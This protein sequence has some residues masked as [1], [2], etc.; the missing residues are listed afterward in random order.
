M[1][2]SYRN[3]GLSRCKDLP[4]NYRALQ[5]YFSNV[6]DLQSHYIRIQS[7]IALHAPAVDT[8][9][10]AVYHC[11]QLAEEFVTPQHSDNTPVLRQA[12][13]AS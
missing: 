6:A 12:T 11:L 3:G 1:L 4:A 5:S 13:G 10:L 9:W 8:G 7:V 2:G